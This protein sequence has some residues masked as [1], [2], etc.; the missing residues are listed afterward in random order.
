MAADD[1]LFTAK[2][3]RPTDPLPELPEI[4]NCPFCGHSAKVDYHQLRYYGIN[5]Y[6]QRKI[7]FGFYVR[8]KRCLARGPVKTATLITYSREFKMQ[9]ANMKIDAIKAWNGRRST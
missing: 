7:R 4:S 6:G 1:L 8:C 3:Q 9:E 5:V 2:T